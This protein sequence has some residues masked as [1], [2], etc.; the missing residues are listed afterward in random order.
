MNKVGYVHLDIEGN[1]WWVE[2]ITLP[3]RAPGGKEGVETFFVAE[4]PKTDKKSFR[5][6]NKYSVLN[7]IG[8]TKCLGNLYRDKYNKLHI[9]YKPNYDKTNHQK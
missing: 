9:V 1:E 5:E 7:K 6:R 2:K 4:C 3:K 8:R